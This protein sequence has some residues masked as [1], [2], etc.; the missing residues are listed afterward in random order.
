M[1]AQETHHTRGQKSRNAK[2]TVGRADDQVALRKQSQ[3]LPLYFGEPSET[4]T[5]Y[6]VRMHCSHYS[7]DA[8]VCTAQSAP[9]RVRV[10]PKACGTPEERNLPSHAKN[11]DLA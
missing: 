9:A 8:R 3:G 4:V 1:R 10:A 5:F 6:A 2:F 11:H 7:C